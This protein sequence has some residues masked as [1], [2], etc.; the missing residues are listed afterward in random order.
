MA[1]DKHTWT[2]DEPITVER[3][4]HMEDGIA[5]AGGGECG[6]ECEEGR[7]TLTE[8]TVTTEFGDGYNVGVLSYSQEINADTI[9]VTF[10]GTEY[11]CSLVDLD[12]RNG[13]GGWN[14]S[15]TGEPDFS[16]YPFALISEFDPTEGGGT[17]LITRFAGS[18]T[19]KIE[20][21]DGMTVT[22]TPCF[23]LA[24]GYSCQARIITE[25]TLTAEA[26]VK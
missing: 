19:I 18:H 5:N 22:T 13:Y 3:L 11:E 15:H 23:D 21:A 17:T 16:Q 4:N 26:G 7:T 2:C 12:G 8:E 1:Y 14:A 10:D 9:V 25:E 20:T 6:Y 24:R